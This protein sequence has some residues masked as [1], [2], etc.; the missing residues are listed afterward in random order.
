M[1]RATRLVAF[2]AQEIGSTPTARFQL[3]ERTDAHSNHVWQRK[4]GT[5][6]GQR[7]QQ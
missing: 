7:Q 4:R 5:A 1:I 2:L 6:A 3:R